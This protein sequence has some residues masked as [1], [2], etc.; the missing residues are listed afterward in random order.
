MHSIILW[1]QVGDSGG[2]MVQW[3]MVRRAT[4]QRQASVGIVPG[5]CMVATGCCVGS[6]GAVVDSVGGDRG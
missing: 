3:L 2:V 5:D 1:Q 4:E 6:D